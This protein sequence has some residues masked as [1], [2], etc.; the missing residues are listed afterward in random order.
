MIL[1]LQILLWLL[2]LLKKNERERARERECVGV[3]VQACVLKVH[4]SFSDPKPSIFSG[5]SSI[6]LTASLISSLPPIT[7]CVLFASRIFYA[8]ELFTAGF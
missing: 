1:M 7:A 4:G 8:V 5:S 3:C 2:L 6:P